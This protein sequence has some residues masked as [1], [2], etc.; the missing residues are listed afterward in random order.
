MGKG[1]GSGVYRVVRGLVRLFYPKPR[2]Q[3]L[4]NLPRESCV[5]VAN[6]AQMNGPI[7]GEVFFPG[8]RAVWCASEM[9]RLKEVP[10]Y[11]FRDFWSQKPRWQLPFYRLLSWLI[12]PL[13][14]AIFNNALTIPVYRD[15]RVIATMKQTVRALSEGTNIILFP[16]KDEK[17]NAVLYAFQ[18]GF[19]DIARL[20]F[21]Q[22]GRALRFVP[23]YVAPRLRLTAVGEP[24]EYCPDNAP[25]A[26]R[27]RVCDA[28][29][30][31]ITDLARALPRHRVV[32]YRNIPR[33][34]YPFNT[35]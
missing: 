27:R 34:D 19:V 17:R 31:R 22:T 7:V 25:E 13:S 4:E 28:L 30:E 16:E 3:G 11:A 32:P 21:R 1:F 10:A 20:Y 9:M 35:D 26:E 6:H 33:R 14:V 8:R 12:A 29:S 5:I 2:F 23:V 18:E 15:G 24:V